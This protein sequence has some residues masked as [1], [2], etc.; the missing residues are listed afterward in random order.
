MPHFSFPN[1]FFFNI[2][3]NE[4]HVETGKYSISTYFFCEVRF[5]ELTI[6]WILCH[7]VKFSP[8]QTY[9]HTFG[10]LFQQKIDYCFSIHSVLFTS[11]ALKTLPHYS[12]PCS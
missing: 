7:G 12:L 9:D 1:F 2:D 3:K 8:I 11:Q 10:S 4:R 5:N 6:I